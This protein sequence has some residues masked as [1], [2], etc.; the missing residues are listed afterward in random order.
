MVQTQPAMSST[1]ASYNKA[2]EAELKNNALDD[3]AFHTRTRKREDGPI[4]TFIAMTKRGDLKWRF[5]P[6]RTSFHSLGHVAISTPVGGYVLVLEQVRDRLGEHF[7]ENGDAH[8]T[9]SITILDS[10]EGHEVF[11]STD[12]GFGWDHTPAQLEKMSAV[13]KTAHRSS[14]ISELYSLVVGD[15]N[16]CKPRR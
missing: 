10:I 8:Y 16:R 3:V 15:Q 1:I 2:L 11:F 12:Q 14:K 9:H 13:E 7:D 4:L 5:A 6:P